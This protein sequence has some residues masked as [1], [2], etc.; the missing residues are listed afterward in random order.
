MDVPAAVA[1][2]AVAGVSV[3]AAAWWLF[4]R[5]VR[6]SASPPDPEAEAARRSLDAERAE[7]AAGRERLAAEVAATR[8]ARAAAEAAEKDARDRLERAAG[9]SADEAK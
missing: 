7:L 9:L 2:G 6:Q 1:V 8:A 4:G 3:A 5:G